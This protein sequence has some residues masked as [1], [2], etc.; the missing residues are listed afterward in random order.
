MFLVDLFVRP[1]HRRDG[2]GGA[3]LIE[4]AAIC[5]RRGY[6][7]LEWHVLDWNTPAQAFYRTLGGRPLDDWTTWRLD[8]AAIRALTAGAVTRSGVLEG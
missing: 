2:H 8:E 1:E 6:T 5:R 7:R 4:L 3:L